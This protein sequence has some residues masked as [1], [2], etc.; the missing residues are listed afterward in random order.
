[1]SNEPATG[2]E[3]LLILRDVRRC[4]ARHELADHKLNEA[5]KCKDDD[6]V[7]QWADEIKRVCAELIEL[8][9]RLH[10]TRKGEESDK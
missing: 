3:R 9:S 10:G 8:E 6:F 1:M 4:A 5:L 2:A 7:A